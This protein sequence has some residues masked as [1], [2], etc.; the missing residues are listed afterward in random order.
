MWRIIYDKAAT[1]QLEKLPPYIQVEIKSGLENHYW[2]KMYRYMVGLR[3]A[4]SFWPVI[5]GNY[6]ILCK[7]SGSR[8]LVDVVDI[9]L[10]VSR[11]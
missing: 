9:S 6:R 7:T 11:E 3:V 8:Q 4:S 1:K 10:N 2:G 5:I